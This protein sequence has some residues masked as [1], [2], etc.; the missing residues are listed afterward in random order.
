MTAAARNL[1]LYPLTEIREIETAAQAIL[2]PGTLMRRAGAAAAAL[3][4]SL[5]PASKQTVLILAGS[6]NNGGDAFETAYL[7]AEQGI[8]VHLYFNGDTSRLPADAHAA[9]L[10]AS[11]SPARF[12]S[13]AQKLPALFPG[14]DLIVDGIFGIGLARPITGAW[15]DLIQMVNSASGRYRIPVLALDTPSGLNAETGQISGTGQIAIR[16]SHTLTFITNKAGLHTADGKD[17]AGKVT[18]DALGIADEVLPTCHT[19]LSNIDAL[20]TKLP[21]RQQNSHKGTYGDVLVIGGAEG[22]CGA[23]ILAARAAAQC[24][25]GRVYAGFL[26]S[27]PAYDPPHPELMLR[28][29]SAIPWLDQVVVIG[30]GMGQD[31][32]AREMLARALR[33][34]HALVLDADALNLLADDSH[35]QDLLQRRSAPSLLTP[36]PLEAARLLGLSASQIQARR[37][38]YA[39]LLAARLNSV[40]V[41]KGSGSLI[42]RPDGELVV[43]TSG[44]PALASGGTGDVLAGVCGALLAQGLNAFDAAQFAVYLHGYGADQLLQ[45]GIGPVGLGASELIPAIRNALN[46]LLR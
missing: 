18:L 23:T 25:A 8:E 2:A 24:G 20:K 14:T 16:A 26:G 4:L 46:H 32:V 36:H 41:L 33:H 22:M 37:L 19:Y 42:C 34:P 28:A 15:A 21:R 44:N 38:E 7:L 9:W 17:F 45:Q 10:R 39:R 43:N 12:L 27:P 5:L 13:E 3:A 11:H 31:D 6:G 35:L 1:A 29:A 30:P 40:V